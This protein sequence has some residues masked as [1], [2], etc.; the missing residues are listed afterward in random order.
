[1]NIAVDP[2]AAGKG[3]GS[4]LIGALEDTARAA[5]ITDLSLATHR[6]MPGNVDFYRKLGW[7]VT[8]R[9]GNRIMMARHLP[10]SDRSG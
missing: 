9:E 7:S 10:S 2:D 3:V 4:A 5:G 1:M 6:D 8:G